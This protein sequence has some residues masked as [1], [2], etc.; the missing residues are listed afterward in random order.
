MVLW[1]IGLSSAGKTTL[2]KEVLRKVKTIQSNVVLIDGDVIREVFS[3]DLGYTLEDRRKN[4]DRICGLCKFLDDQGINVLCAILSLFP[5]SRLWNREN[6]K[7]YYEVYIDNTIED[8]EQ[9]DYKGL[10]RKYNKG[11]IKN[12]PGMDIEFVPP[13]N[14]DLIIKNDGEIDDLLKH[15]KFLS[16]L[17]SN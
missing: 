9:R 4:A 2:A 15:S 3:N 11:K 14:P 17:F 7:N 6:I 8:L 10:Y 5:E 12:V 16:K 1:I 13:T